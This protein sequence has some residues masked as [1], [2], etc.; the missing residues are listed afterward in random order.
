MNGRLGAVSSMRLATVLTFVAACA[1]FVGYMW[2][3]AGGSIAGFKDIDG[4][5]F[6]AEVADVD[7]LVQFS[8]VAIA[9]VP[10]GKID[11]LDRLPDRAHLDIVLDGDVPTLHQGATVQVS[12]KS[13]A[14]QSYLKVVDGTGAAMPSGSA[15]PLSASRPSV[16]LRD[17]LAG[18]DTPTKQALGSSI[19][20][21]GQST[22][23]R[24]PDVA[25]TMDGLAKLGAG[26]F[27]ALDA[28]QAQSEDIKNL[29]GE[30]TTVLAAL[31]AGQND[32]E[33]TV[34]G[35]SEIV[36]ATA[37]Q[38]AP[39]EESMRLLPGFLH[40]VQGSTSGFTRIG[41]ALA[42]VAA[43]LRTAAPD[44]TEALTQLPDMTADLRDLVDPL[45]S[46]LDRAPATLSRVEPFADDVRDLVPHLRNAL[47]DVN[48]TLEYASP[49]GRDIGAFIANFHAA[50]AATSTDGSHNL[51][52][53]PL[54]NEFSVRGTGPVGLRTG[55]TSEFNPLPRPNMGTDPGPFVGPYPR[56]DR[57]P[58]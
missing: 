16:Q 8:D 32:L 49:Y 42:P 28:L 46:T 13:L 41:G 19:R 57:Q 15:L 31:D 35:T 27:T 56:L 44:L 18:L 3:H 29:G 39:L 7:N 11:K 40:K 1:V 2:L 45:A 24:A 50:F 5:R 53:Y 34:R 54:F 47:Q 51:R 22:Q 6:S 30:L 12:E 14:G 38:R 20:S 37:G 55:P 4:Y 48:P 25:A 26:G 9:G 21:L 33:T 23:G 52:L 43:D 10:V 17:V 36:S 58:R